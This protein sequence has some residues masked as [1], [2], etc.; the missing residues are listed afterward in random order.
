MTYHKSFKSPKKEFRK[1]LQTKKLVSPLP[2]TKQFEKIAIVSPNADQ[3]KKHFCTYIDS[4]TNKRCK[5]YLGVYPEFCQKHTMAI[6][7]IFVDTS[8]IKNAGRGLFAGEYKF[9]KGD[10]IGEYSMPEI[11]LTWGDIENRADNPNTSYVYC[12]N[13]KRGQDESE[14]ECWDALDYRSSV[15]RYANDAH[16]SKFKNNAEFDMFRRKRTKH[17][18]A[19]I[20]IYIVATKTI[21]PYKEIYLSYGGLYF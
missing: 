14:M 7:N 5:N 12:E 11:K 6:Q 18:K 10:I 1:F 16:G 13:P 8:N 4:K 3:Q 2:Y 19:E 15:M 17:G 21:H 20:R 9:K